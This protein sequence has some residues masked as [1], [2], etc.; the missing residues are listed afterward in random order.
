MPHVSLITLGV[1]DLATTSTFYERL[2]WRRSSASVTDV[3]T[4][5]QGDNIVLGLFGRAELAADAALPKG[6]LTG[7][8]AVALATNLPD[9]SA[10]D[11]FLVEV[12]AAGGQVVKPAERAEWGGYSGYFTDPEGHLWEVAYNPGFPLQED[13]QV[14]LPT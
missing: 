14:S 10:V 13:G 2:G 9:E 1:D 7:R 3:V 8:A 12:E 6:S 5:L 11:A 4:F